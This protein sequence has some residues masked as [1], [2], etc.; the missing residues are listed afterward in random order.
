VETLSKGYVMMTIV[1]YIDR[2]GRES[3][4]TVPPEIK[5]RLEAERDLLN[6]FNSVVDE[7]EGTYRLFSMISYSLYGDPKAW[8]TLP[9]GIFKEEI[10]R[11][12]YDED[13]V[14]KI[15]RGENNG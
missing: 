10:L 5:D 14:E 13:D 11:H 6:S 1:K 15:M 4:C 8:E 7:L 3:V 9:P 2:H 12:F